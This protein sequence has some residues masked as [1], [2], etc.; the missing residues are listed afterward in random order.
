[1]AFLRRFNDKSKALIVRAKNQPSKPNKSFRFGPFQFQPFSVRLR[2]QNVHEK[3]TKILHKSMTVVRRQLNDVKLLSAFFH[4]TAQTIRQLIM[5]TKQQVGLAKESATA[6]DI[7]QKPSIIVVAL[8]LLHRFF[9]LCVRFV[10]VKVHGEHGP[11]MPPI[12]DLLLL[13]SATSIA[14][15]I[16]TKKVAAKHQQFIHTHRQ[17]FAISIEPIKLIELIECLDIVFFSVLGDINAGYK[18]VYSTNSSNQFTIELC[19]G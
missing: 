18:S 8:N 14:E 9:C 5:A 16:R 2:A 15:M 10:L 4:K 17:I 3:F 6:T 7:V 11:S 12:D 19:G 1:M 13:E